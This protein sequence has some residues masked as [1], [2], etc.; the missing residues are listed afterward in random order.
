M[1]PGNAVQ[2][3]L[4]AL[5]GYFD[6]WTHRMGIAPDWHVLS[7]TPTG[8]RTYPLAVKVENRAARPVDIA[9]WRVPS[10]GWRYYWT[11]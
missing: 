10:L 3:G 6:G 5:S 8:D 4:M 9:C 7:C 1:S 11:I 2:L